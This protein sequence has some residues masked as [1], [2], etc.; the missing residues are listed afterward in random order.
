MFRG[1]YFRLVLG[2]V[3]FMCLRHYALV[4]R[5]SAKHLLGQDIGSQVDGMF[6]VALWQIMGDLQ[7]QGI[8]N[9]FVQRLSTAKNVRLPA[10][11]SQD[12]HHTEGGVY[13]TFLYDPY[14]NSSALRR[15]VEAFRD[16]T[17][18]Q[19][20][21][22][23]IGAGTHAVNIGAS[24]GNYVRTVQSLASKAHALRPHSSLGSKLSQ[25]SGP[26]NLIL[27]APADIHPNS[28]T[29]EAA[30]YRELNKQLA[31]SAEETPFDFL[32][33][34]SEMTDSQG[35]SLQ[36][37]GG[38]ATELIVRTRAELLL[39]LRCNDVL[40]SRGMI[41]NTATCCAN[42]RAANWIQT[43][44]IIIALIL[45]PALLLL[46]S[47][48]SI[49]SMESRTVVYALSS[50]SAVIVMLFIADRSQVFE[51]AR[52][53]VFRWESWA[54]FG[55]V[56]AVF[57]ATTIKRCT[58][59]KVQDQQSINNQAFLPREQADEWKG[60][61]QLVIIIFH[62]G[63]EPA[64]FVWIVG[65][66][67]VPSYLFISGF[68]HTLYFLQKKDYSLQRFTGVLMRTNLPTVALAYVMRTSWAGYYY[69]AL[70]TIW[71]VILYI[72]LATGRE[73]NSNIAF[74]LGKIV[75]S[76]T[77]VDLF[78]STEGAQ[79][80][81]VRLCTDFT[82]GS[83]SVRFFAKRM[84]NDRYMVYIGMVVALLYIWLI[85]VIHKPRNSSEN[86]I[87][88]LSKVVRKHWE[89]LRISVVGCALLG[90][91]AF[92]YW[93]S[94]LYRNDFLSYQAYVNWIP[95][96]CYAVMRNAHPALRNF[97]SAGFA[98]LGRY[99][100]EMYIMH[101]HF[102]L[103]G[104]QGSVLRTG[105]FHGD[106]TLL[107]DRWRDWIVLTPLYIASSIVVGDATGVIVAWFV[108]NRQV[109]LT[110]SAGDGQ[111]I[112]EAGSASCEKLGVQS[113]VTRRIRY[114]G[115]MIHGLQSLQARIVMALMIMWVLN[116]TYT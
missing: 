51:H 111:A 59:Q 93:Q 6:L 80:T 101:F 96:I 49:L 112:A 66:S 56:A 4:I 52:K 69:V 109:P 20:M 110:V 5:T 88:R 106:E 61:M 14:L 36:G 72:T 78:F 7:L 47:Q 108:G 65:R 98:W 64:P 3:G 102:W 11:R 113:T 91:C 115:S 67:I 23:V 31:R 25:D 50:F 55:L 81:L 1:I 54:L 100:G 95:I 76:A 85:G 92:W 12:L 40:A 10:L 53:D 114:R 90:S 22:T 30:P 9:H 89:V 104:D 73:Y 60:W 97:H 99:S 29:I 33:V 28:P 46:D 68:G 62:Y 39:S 43:G 21:L 83:F 26:G 8:Y 71:F 63:V 70:S 48:R 105:F 18:D 37:P 2:L 34:F 35:Q 107:R 75:L 79:E 84:F 103:S 27:F 41:S 82:G 32:P 58:T 116:W 38:Q 42:W 15:A 74:M 57:G 17:E 45:L 13:L 87:S 86:D 44:F 16:E 19:P 94:A 24:L 77:L